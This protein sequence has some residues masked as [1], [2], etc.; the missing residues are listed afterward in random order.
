MAKITSPY[1]RSVEEWIGSTP[2]AMPPKSVRLRIFDRYMGHCYVTGKKLHA[3]EWDLDHIRRLRD[4]GENRESNLAPIY[5]PK[6]REKT[7]QENTE[8]AAVRRK[9]EKHVL[10]RPKGSIP[11]RPKEPK[12]NAKQ[13]ALKRLGPPR[14][15]RDF[16]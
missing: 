10:G 12:P 9:R 11:Q 2:D 3:G 8:G 4:G 7:A 15:G 5:R 1:G 14:L 6:H 13:E 16:T